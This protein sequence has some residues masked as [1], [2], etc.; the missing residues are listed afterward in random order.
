MEC[1]T[2]ATLRIINKRSLQRIHCIRRKGEKVYF[3]THGFRSLKAKK[4]YFESLFISSE[5]FGRRDLN[6]FKTSRSSVVSVLK[7]DLLGC[8]I[9]Y[10][11]IKSDIRPFYSTSNFGIF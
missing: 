1:K 3:S 11:L 5:F 6:K 10:I 9:L 2:L 8:S 7:I 4:I